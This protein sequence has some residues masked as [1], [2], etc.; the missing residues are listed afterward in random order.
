MTQQSRPNSAL[1]RA[2]D[3]EDIMRLIR[4]ADQSGFVSGSGLPTRVSPSPENFQPKGFVAVAEAELPPLVDDLPEDSIEITAR[5][6]AEEPAPAQ[7]KIDIEAIRKEAWAE[8][9]QAGLA[10]GQAKAHL[11]EPEEPAE[12]RSDEEAIAAAREEAYALAAAEF[13]EARDA[14]VAA[15]QRLLTPDTDALAGL[16]DQLTEAVRKLASDR[17]GVQIDTTPARFVNR[18]EALVETVASGITDVTIRLHPTDLDAVSPH[19]SGAPIVQ[20]SRLIADPKLRRGDVGITTP[21][22]T[23]TDSLAKKGAAK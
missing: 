15:T 23:L 4:E 20:Q 7:P 8:G 2:L 16:R 19:L 18:I 22:I 3:H 1:S 11:T 6:A 14:F 12:P 9:Y 5:P 21:D 17:A 13:A 10:E